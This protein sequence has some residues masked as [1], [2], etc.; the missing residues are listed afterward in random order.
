[1]DGMSGR[2]ATAESRLTLRCFG[3]KLYAIRASDRIF[4]DSDTLT[5][6]KEAKNLIYSATFYKSIEEQTGAIG[7]SDV[8]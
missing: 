3:S 1:M 8:Y 2:H 4:R 7:F 5:L 6:Q